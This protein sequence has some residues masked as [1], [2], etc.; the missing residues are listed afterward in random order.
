MKALTQIDISN[1]EYL[2]IIGYLV[3]IAFVGIIFKKF[4]SDTDDYFKSGS[5]ASWWLVGSS[6]ALPL[7]PV[8]R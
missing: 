8:F 6:Q 1:I 4:S 3:L 2:V 7:S 5:K